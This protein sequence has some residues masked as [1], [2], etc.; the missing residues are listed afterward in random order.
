[1]EKQTIK[2]ALM[3]ILMGSSLLLA[4]CVSLGSKAPP[5]L[6][7]LTSAATVDDG[8]ANIGA[9]KDALIVLAP[10]VP[11]KLD[12]NRVPVQISSSSLAYLKDA[13][14][15]DK[16]ARLMQQLLMETIAAKNN[17]L[18]LNEADAGGQ[19]QEFLS[20]NLIEFGVD[21]RRNEAI[22]I[23]DAVKIVRGEAVKKQ[24]FA[25]RKPVSLIEPVPV[26]AAL[27]LAANEIAA[28]ISIWIKS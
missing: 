10:L 18:V 24:R 22:I 1:M 25:V 27:N 28:E 8:T 16:P 20:G 11:R 6:L 13:V 4:G 26:S 15:A 5:S 7:V 14:W 19:A 9:Q 2:S 12:T 3:P 21:A 17:R 23:Y